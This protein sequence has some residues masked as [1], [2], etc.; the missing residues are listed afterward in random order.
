MMGITPDVEGGLTLDIDASVHVVH[1]ENKQ[2]AAAGYKGLRLPSDVLFSR[3][4]RRGAQLDAETG[5]R[6]CEQHR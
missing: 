5:Q 6:G 1:S 2:G 4:H 3:Y